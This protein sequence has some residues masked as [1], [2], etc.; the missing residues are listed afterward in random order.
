MLPLPKASD[1]AAPQTVQVS[2]SPVCSP[3]FCVFPQEHDCQCFCVSYSQP[4]KSQMC[5]RKSILSRAMPQ[6][7]PPI[8][9]HFSRVPSK[10]ALSIIVPPNAASPM[11]SRVLGS[12]KFSILPQFSNA[13]APMLFMPPGSVSRL[14]TLH[15]KNAFAPISVTV[16]G[17][18]IL[19]SSAQ[20]VNIPSGIMVS[21]VGSSTMESPSQSEK[22]SLPMD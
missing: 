18:V 16:S 13:A 19:S 10:L 15:L 21:V 22:A 17:I 12:S 4:L 8:A 3:S 1:S 9:A 6:P 14:N 7:S 20:S 2:P 11:L 5:S